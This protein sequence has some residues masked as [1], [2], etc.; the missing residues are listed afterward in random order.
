MCRSTLTESNNRTV[1]DCSSWFGLT[2]NTQLWRELREHDLVPP[3]PL[4]Q[5]S[6]YPGQRRNPQPLHSPCSVSTNHLQASAC[7]ARC[8]A[9][10]LSA[11]AAR[12]SRADRV[13]CKPRLGPVP[14]LPDCR[15]SA[16]A[17][18]SRASREVYFSCSS[19]NC[20]ARAW[21]ALASS[22]APHAGP[23]VTL[24]KFSF[25]LDPM[26]KI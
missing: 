1:C 7:S 11:L 9:A 8:S 23:R 19:A 3:G 16:Q 22:F 26:D 10:S 5:T 13:A 2:V 17:L 24:C 4:Q 20:L 18:V 14:S 25:Y 21:A 12:S 15:F 6:M